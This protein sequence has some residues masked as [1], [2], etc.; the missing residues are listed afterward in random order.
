[1]YIAGAALLQGLEGLQ[2][3]SDKREDCLL[4][5]TEVND[6]GVVGSQQVYQRKLQRVEVL[7]LVNLNPF[8]L[9]VWY[10][11]FLTSFRS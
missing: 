5:V 10:N 1:M 11:C 9:F 7:H 6:G 4:L 3:G 8:I 2:L